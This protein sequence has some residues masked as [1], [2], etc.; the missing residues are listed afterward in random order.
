MRKP[1]GRI[2]RDT[3]NIYYADG[4]GFVSLIDVPN[5]VGADG[6]YQPVFSPT[7]DVSNFPCSVQYKQEAEGVMDELNR[8]TEVR[9][10]AILCNSDPQVDPRDAIIY[11]DNSGNSH[12]LFVEAS[13]DQAGRGSCWRIQ[14]TERR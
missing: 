3:I 12:T 6:G 7:P 9:R 13:N 10:Y 8:V 1:S 4:T 11:I 14:A 2:M 5:Q